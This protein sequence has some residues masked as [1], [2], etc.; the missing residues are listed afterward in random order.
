V[1]YLINSPVLTAFGQ[2][3]FDGP[4]S[5]E[6]ARDWLRRGY[7]SAIGHE[8]TARWLSQLLG[9]EVPPNRITIEM[10][11]GDEALVVK[12]LQRL[13]EGVVLGDDALRQ[14]PFELG[15]LVRVS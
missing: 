15:R 5:I 10:Q 9:M 8:S 4:L 1:R 11:P 7:V 2:Y 6:D 3:R 14:V 13:P 12:L